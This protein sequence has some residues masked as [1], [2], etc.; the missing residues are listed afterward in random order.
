MATTVID[1]INNPYKFLFFISSSLQLI[2]NLGSVAGAFDVLAEGLRGLKKM[3]KNITS[4]SKMSLLKE[5]MIAG[6]AI[7]VLDSSSR[8]LIAKYQETG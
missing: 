6:Q 8:V 1:E 4:H 3:K 2:R 5:M 7:T